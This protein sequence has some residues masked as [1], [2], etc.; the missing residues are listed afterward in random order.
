MSS[1]AHI[2]LKLTVF[3]NFTYILFGAFFYFQKCHT[4][5]FVFISMAIIYLNTC[6]DHRTNQSFDDRNVE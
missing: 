2:P 1:S 5:V 3:E 4:I 6:L